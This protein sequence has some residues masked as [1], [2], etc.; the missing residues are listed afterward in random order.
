MQVLTPRVNVDALATAAANSGFRGRLLGPVDPA[1]GVAV[2]GIA[3]T[4][5]A[6]GQFVNPAVIANPQYTVNSAINSV[7]VAPAIT[8]DIGAGAVV[9]SVAVTPVLNS[10]AVTSAITN[11]TT[12]VTPATIAT[13]NAATTN[14]AV[15][16]TPSTILTPTNAAIPTTVGQMAAGPGVSRTVIGNVQ[17]GTLTP[18]VSSGAVISPVAAANPRV[19]GGTSTATTSRVLP[20][21]VTNTAGGSIAKP[22]VISQSG[23]GITISNVTTSKVTTSTAGAHPVLINQPMTSS[24]T[25]NSTGGVTTVKP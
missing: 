22:I 3:G 9:S 14:G 12:G 25:T 1:T 24:S 17:N 23:G 8:G 15:I 2:T 10:G 19:I 18:T 5:Y 16:T 7:G 11:L 4:D 6:T 20:F 13:G 21:A